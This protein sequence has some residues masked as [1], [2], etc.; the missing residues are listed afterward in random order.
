MEFICASKSLN[1]N[2]IVA[3]DASGRE[4]F[5][6]AAKSTWQI[7]DP[8][9]RPRPLSPQPLF[10]ADAFYGKP[11]ESALRNGNDFPRY[12]PRCDVILDACAHAPDGQSVTQL[13]AGFQ[14]GDLRKELRVIGDRFWTAGVFGAKPSEPVVFSRMPLNYEYAFGGTRQFER[15]GQTLSEAN[16]QNPMG[17]GWGGKHTKHDVIAKRHKLPNL[18]DPQKPVLNPDDDIAPFALGALSRACL[19]RRKYMGSFDEKWRMEVAPFLPEDFDDR[20][21]QVVP[22][23]Q[24]MPYP[25]GGEKVQLVNLVRSQPAVA[26][27]LPPL[28][29]VKLHVLRTDYSTEVIEAHAD[30][31][32]FETE[33]KRFSVTWRAS[34]PVR[35]RIQEFD[36]IAIGAVNADWWQ[37][38]ALG[39]ANS[40][41]CK[42]CSGAGTP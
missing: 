26:F 42:G 23:D 40:L 24:Q 15:N 29:R 41:G 17:R 14:V 37:E 35:R 12:K 11:A 16:L 39:G 3:L 28:D 2:F 30:T 1:A 25:K 32:F 33:A 31:L 10:D 7:P 34:T 38:T 9:S 8:G 13:T 4:H 36:V 18:E 6:V 21:N 5:V 27:R 19:A 20:F 22:E